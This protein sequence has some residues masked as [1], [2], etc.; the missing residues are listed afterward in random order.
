MIA[1]PARRTSSARLPGNTCRPRRG[2]HDGERQAI[3]AAIVVAAAAAGFF[4]SRLNRAPA[5]DVPPAA[6]A[7]PIKPRR[8]V[9][10]L[11]FKNLSQRSDVAWLSTALSEMLTSELAAGEKLRMI[12]ANKSSG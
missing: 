7:S 2:P 12:P 5:A 10:V 11:G 1:S 9:A 3:A 8:A 6:A 4:A